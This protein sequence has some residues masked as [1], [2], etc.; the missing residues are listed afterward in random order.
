MRT[1][2]RLAAA[3]YGSLAALLRSWSLSLKAANKSPRTI[4]SYLE[5]GVV[6]DDFL[7]DRFGLADVAEVAREHVESFVA[8]QLARWKPKTASIRYG[9]LQQLFK[10][11]LD[12]G[13]IRENPMARMTPPKVPE[14]PIPVIPDEHL[15]KL[16]KACSGTE[17]S[18]RRDTAI[19]R[20]LIDGGVRLAEVTN[21]SV[22]DVDLGMQVLRV[23]GKGSRPRGVPFGPKTATALDRYLRS[24]A[25]QKNAELP[26]LWLNTRAGALSASG[27]A[28]VIRRRCDEAGI[29]HLHPHQFR[30]TSAHAWF[31]A[32]GGETDA[33]RLYGWNSRAMLGRYA[34]ATADERAREAHRRL[35]PGDRL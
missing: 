5:T 29:A 15:K 13:E 3:E 35:L 23:L 24:R 27:I 7:R 31:S 30:H 18:D 11:L 34:S 25:R 14:V 19:L 4:D 22:E 2:E 12:E 28:Q 21:L 17:F 33:M 26:A 10:W 16:L 20:V 1:A 32:G 9:N 6:F 8:D